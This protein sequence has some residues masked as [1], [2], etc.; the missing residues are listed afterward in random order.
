MAIFKQPYFLRG[1]IHSFAVVVLAAAF[2][3][4]SCGIQN[5]HLQLVLTATPDSQVY[6]KGDY[7]DIGLTLRNDSRR[8]LY[9]S[10]LIAGSIMV[11]SLTKDGLPVPQRVVDSA[12]FDEFNAILQNSL[13][14]VAAGQSLSFVWASQRDPERGG[15]LDPA[16]GG[17]SLETVEP[18]DQWFQKKT[19]YA[20]DEPG[21]YELQI[22]YHYRGPVTGL[23]DV[24]TTASNTVTV[25]FEV[26]P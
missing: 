9:A 15:L 2:S 25:V 16:L 17:Q 24:F 14:S 11:A 8:S 4:T 19:I 23:S 12:Y 1:E 21:R 22:F 13:K 7:I 10:D 20:L 18:K 3:L 26:T 5:A 6:A